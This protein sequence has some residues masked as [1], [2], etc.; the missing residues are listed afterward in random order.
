MDGV[1]N[2]AKKRESVTMGG[3]GRGEMRNEI[4]RVTGMVADAP[5]TTDNFGNR[6]GTFGVW[7]MKAGKLEILLMVNGLVD[8]NGFC[9]HG[10]ILIVCSCTLLHIIFFLTKTSMRVEM[11]QLGFR[12]FF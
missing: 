7:E 11:C 4:R 12:V 10:I 9:T 3:K 8:K 6:F 2:L 5:T 1:V